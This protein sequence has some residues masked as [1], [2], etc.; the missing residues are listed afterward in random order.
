MATMRN[1]VFNIFSKCDI[2]EDSVFS[3]IDMIIVSLL[4]KQLL[5]SFD[6]CQPAIYADS[7]LYN[8]DTSIYT[9]AQYDAFKVVS[10]HTLYNPSH[11]VNKQILIMFI[12]LGLLPW[13]RRELIYGSCNL[14]LLAH[15]MIVIMGIP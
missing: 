3:Y 15:Y 1:S 7:S 8:I 6:Y 10:F 5:L 11:T 4:N 9:V 13:V 12:K 14:D 2:N